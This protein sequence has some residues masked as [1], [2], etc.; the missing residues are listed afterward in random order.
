MVKPKKDNNV[1]VENRYKLILTNFPNLSIADIDYKV[2]D[3]DSRLRAAYNIKT[4]DA[5]II[6]TGIAVKADYFIT[7]DVKLKRICNEVGVQ[8]VLIE[9]I[10]G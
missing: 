4:P 9:N 8:V 5:L 10:E 3:I 7:N 6:A 2:A 1:F